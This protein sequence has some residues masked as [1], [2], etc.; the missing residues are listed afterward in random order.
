MIAILKLL[1][2]EDIT[3][4]TEQAVESEVTPA[5]KQSAQNLKD[6]RR[7]QMDFHDLGIP[8]GSNLCSKNGQS[9]ATFA[10]ARTV[11]FCGDFVFF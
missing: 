7:P 11:D 1:E 2:V 10:G 3:R 8:K 9:E 4:Q 5:D 6:A